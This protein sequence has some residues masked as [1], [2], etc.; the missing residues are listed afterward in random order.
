MQI[1][2]AGTDRTSLIDWPSV[3]C[4]QV[5]T[6]S[7]DELNFRIKKFGTKNYTPAVNDEVI[8]TH[9]S[10]RIFAGYIVKVTNDIKGLAQFQNVI[11]K[12]YS[13]ILENQLISKTYTS[14]TVAAIIADI[15][16]NYAPAGFTTAGVNANVAVTKMIFNYISISQCFKKMADLLKGYE[17][18][19]D[20]NKDIKFF[21]A[22]T[23]SAPFG[24]TDT[25][26]KFIK[27]SLELTSDI[28]QLANDVTIRGGK[29]IGTGTR[30]EYWS[31]DGTRTN[32]PLGNDFNSLPTVTVGGV[33]KTVGVDGLDED[34]SFVCMWNQNSQLI[35]FTSGNTPVAGTN[36]IA[37]TGTPQFPLTYQKQHNISI[38]T[39]GRKPRFV[40]DTNIQ[41]IL[42]A[43]QRADSELEY[44]AFPVNSGKF[45]TYESGLA[46]GQ[47]ININSTIRGVNVDYKIQS[48]TVTCYSPTELKYSIEIQTAKNIGINDILTKLLIT[49]P[50]AKEDS[51]ANEIVLRVSSFPETL[52]INDTVGT[53]TKTTAPYVWG[54]FTWGLGKWS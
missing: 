4:R 13:Y 43:S 16:A 1:T 6:K 8:F 9:N 44:Y 46:I 21:P 15:M 23:V 26:G 29:V 37:I 54:S 40:K 3:R 34:A 33:S 28:S 35:R 31:G 2:I 12:D 51:N 11:V 10:V 42:S 7:S 53:P 41:D 45:S 30:T 48:I 19:V 39:Y 17:W 50:A 32:F 14:T 22:G 38:S 49:D 52:D 24:L 20:Y 25:N 18:Y 5:L 36:N 27:D 47:S